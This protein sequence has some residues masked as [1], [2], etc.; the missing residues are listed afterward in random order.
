L[1]PNAF[2][3]FRHAYGFEGVNTAFDGGVVEYS[4]N[5]GTT[6][7]DAGSLITIN[8][9]NK[10]ISSSFGNPL[11]GQQAFGTKSKGYIS[12]RAN[13]SSLAGQNVRFRFR[14]GTDNTGDALGWFIDDVRIYTCSGT[15][16]N[17][18]PT[19]SAS[20]QLVTIQASGPKT[21]AVAI[22]ADEQ[23]SAGSLSVAVA[24]VPTGMTLT[25][26]NTDGVVFATIEAGCTTPVGTYH[27]TLIVSD[28]ASLTDRAAFDIVVLPAGQNVLDPSFELGTPNP[29]WGEESTVFG[30][31]LCDASC[32]TGGGTAAPRTGDWWV[33]FGGTAAAETGVVSQ[34]I[35]IPAGASRLNFYLWLGRHSGNGASDYLRVTLGGTEIFKITDASTAY[36]GSYHLV[37]IDTSAFA[38]TSRVLRIEEHNNAVSGGVFTVNVD[39]VELVGDA[40]PCLFVSVPSTSQ[41][42]SEDVG[43]VTISATL[44]ITSTRPVTVPLT[45]SGTATNGSDYTLSANSISIAPGELSGS[46]TLTVTDDVIGEPDETVVVTLGTPS[47][48]TLGSPSVETITIQD[49]NDLTKIYLPLVRK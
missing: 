33:W 5:G 40:N 16:I 6:W 13:L 24:D 43:T 3:H 1:V 2:L 30:T 35:A 48:A 37:S 47:G 8:G 18:A 25:V 12:S 39:D 27:A 14:I 23:Q 26:T 42:V 44:S 20:G 34:T 17:T 19:I 15:P 38:G 11:G 29:A 21:A 32:G 7:T 41:T 9:Y 45:L 31:P 28:N 46:V 4:T 49:N 10:T 36:D 22:V